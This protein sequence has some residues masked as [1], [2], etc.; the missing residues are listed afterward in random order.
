MV[1]SVGMNVHKTGAA[2]H[3]TIVAS[4]WHVKLYYGESWSHILWTT[5]FKHDF[6]RQKVCEVCKY[7]K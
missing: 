2:L 7:N 3:G 6:V 5:T 1:E 4:N